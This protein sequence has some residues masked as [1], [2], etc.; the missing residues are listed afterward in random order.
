MS[1]PTKSI[2]LGATI[3]LFCILGHQARAEPMTAQ[4]LE[5]NRRACMTACSQR[6]GDAS[7]CVAY[8]DCGTKGIAER[9]TEEEY[10]AGKLAISNHQR[11]AD[12]SI[13]K[14]ILVAQSCAA[15][16]Q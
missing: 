5:E 2:L 11:P 4:S 13:E 7:R 14:V 16:L 1:S 3:V 12:A 9:M 8:C 10:Q 6:T 15:A